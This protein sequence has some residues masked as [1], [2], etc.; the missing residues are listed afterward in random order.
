MK[1]TSGKRMVTGLA[2]VGV[3]LMVAGSALAQYWGGPWGGYGPHGYGPWGHDRGAMAQDRQHLMSQHE[4]TM[5]DLKRMFDGRRTFDRTEATK[6]AREIEAGAG[7]NLWRL[8]APGSQRPGSR[9]APTVWGSFD[10]FKSHSEA[11]KTAAADL[12]EALE[13]R[14]TAQ[15]WR[16]GQ[17]W[18]PPMSARRHAPWGGPYGRGLHDRWGDRGGAMTREAVDAFNKLVDVCHRCHANFRFGRW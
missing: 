7:E 18:V 14:P 1:T 15:D 9:S 2:A 13:A 4:T 10:T 6:L 5:R 17:V 8:Y 11:L 12:A 3:G 16:Q